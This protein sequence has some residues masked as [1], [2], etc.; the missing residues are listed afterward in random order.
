LAI[1]LELKKEIE[2]MSNEFETLK[3][4]TNTLIGKVSEA[5][6]EIKDLNSKIAAGNL[7][8]AAIQALTAQVD[9]AVT[10]LEGVLPAAAPANDG[11]NAAQ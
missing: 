1:T 3:A 9:E 11:T 4:S 7:D 8:P 6:T 5:I 10:A 2:R